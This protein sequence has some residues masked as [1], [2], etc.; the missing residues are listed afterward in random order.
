MTRRE[1]AGGRPVID[2]GARPGIILAAVA[3]VQLMVSLDLSI[4]N[5]GRPQ[6]AAGL[7]FSA[8]GPP[9]RAEQADDRVLV[10]ARD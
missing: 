1:S 8:V 2:S 9:S 4:V 5:V 10:P 6:I 3:V 7:G